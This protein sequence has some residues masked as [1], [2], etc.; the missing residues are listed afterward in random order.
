MVFLCDMDL[1]QT[2]PP[3]CYICHTFFFL[4]ASLIY[5]LNNKQAP[6]GHDSDSNA[7]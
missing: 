7:P 4:K 2:P 3:E 5:G 1:L 6:T